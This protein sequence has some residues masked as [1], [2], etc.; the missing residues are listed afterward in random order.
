ML[1]RD[2]HG[3]S[4]WL[5][6]VGT[7][8][9]AWGA[10]HVARA[11]DGAVEVRPVERW[12]VG[13]RVL[14]AVVD[15]GVA[16]V[17]LESLAVLDQPAGL[18]ATWIDTGGPLSPFEGSPM[19]LADVHDGTELAS[20]LSRTP[21]AERDTGALLAAM[22]TASTSAATLGTALATEGADVQIAWQSLFA[23]RVG[24]LDADSAASSPLASAM[25]SLMRDA[26]AAQACGADACETW[27]EG[28]RAVVRFA[29]QGGR[30]VV[31]AIIE[32]A[33]VT[34]TSATGSPSRAVP[35]TPDAEETTSLLRMRAR[36]VRQVLGQ[37][38]LAADGGTIGVGLTDLAPDAPIVVVREGAAARVFAIDAGAVRAEAGEARWDAA[39][40]DVDGD[41]RTDVIVSM[42][43]SG[44]GGL[45]LSWT[46]AFVAPPPSVQALSLEADLASALVLMGAPDA[47]SAARAAASIPLR[48][49]PRDDAC[50]LLAA[51][52]TPTGFRRQAA[53][54]A[55]L[56][57]F[58][59]PGMPTWRPKVVS[60]GNLAVDDV[61]GVGAHCAD[62]ACDATRPYCAWSGGADS[63]HFWFGW[64][65]GRLEI[66]G[67]ADYDGE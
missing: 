45:P 65:G 63:E 47:T 64:R 18:H 58:S 28:G 52:T 35:A 43:G 57:H 6:F 14:G 19:A 33:P 4:R 7:R 38:P 8:E 39:F 20:R 41:G 29:R 24:H 51:A 23:Q 3:R 32:D 66:A 44:A 5:A 21:I 60:L 27:T 1:P 53:P 62:L 50:R 46:Q 12:P 2:A 54:D 36:E 42:S 16:Y 67:A 9:V 13:V 10:W 56:L 26:L 61:R 11:E 48:A 25:L 37:A 55:R 17:L 31:R 34:R 30:W 59:A 22:R 40:A 15:H 49:V